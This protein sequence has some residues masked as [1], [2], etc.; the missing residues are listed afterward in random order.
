[1]LKG[2]ELVESVTASGIRYEKRPAKTPDG[3]AAAGLHNAWIWL[4]N[5]AQYNSYTTEMVKGLILAFRAASTARDVNA[6]VFTAAA[7]TPRNTPSTTPAVRRNTGSTCG[8]STIWSRPSLPA[9]SR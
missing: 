8:S 6:V 1:M 7:A 4:D 3:R 5:A 9:T 2:H